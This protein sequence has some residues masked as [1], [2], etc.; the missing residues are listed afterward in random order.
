MPAPVGRKIAYLA[1]RSIGKAI[2]DLQADSSPVTPAKALALSKLT[3]SLD[4]IQERLRKTHGKRRLR[5][6]VASSVATPNQ[7]QVRQSNLK[8]KEDQTQVGSSDEL[9]SP[10]PDKPA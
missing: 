7:T 6:T 3:L 9:G 2:A 10:V 5:R 1:Q 8:E 4:R